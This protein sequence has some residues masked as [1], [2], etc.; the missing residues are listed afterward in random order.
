MAE[1]PK[2]FNDI[3]AFKAWEFDLAL[4]YLRTRRKDGGIAVI[5]IISFLGIALAVT[6]LIA[7]M[8]IM[9]GFQTE[10]MSRLLAFNGHA[11]VYGPPLNALATRDQMLKSIRSLPGI[12][13]ASPYVE[14]P[15]LSQGETTQ[16]VPAF[17]RGVAPATLKANDLIRKSIDPKALDSFGQGAFG[18]EEILIGEGLAQSLS[19]MPGDGL[20]LITLGGSSAFGTLPKRKTYIVGGLFKSG[21][22]ELDASF[23]YMPLDQAALFFGREGDWD[24]VEIKVADP[25]HIE[26]YEAALKVAAGEGAL[27]QSWKVRNTALWSALKFE[28]AA[29]R[30]IL[31]FVVMIA[32]L[33]II[34]GVVMLVKNKTR[35]IAILRTLGAARSS[36]MRI[37]F[38]SG[39]MIGVAGTFVGLCLG[40]LFVVFIRPIQDALEFIFN[41]KLFDPKIYYLSHVPAQLQLGEVLTI[42]IGSLLMACLFTL[43]PARWAARLEPVEALRYE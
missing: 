40:V 7:V 12:I 39:A 16:I 15:A 31:F 8:S 9:N 41:A 2:G 4:R 11:Y 34:S 38:L 1:N 13:E 6:A 32:A 23:I 35:D 19:V 10:L 25:Y 43:F 24:V 22:S 5:A 30:F 36:I 21:V 29:M 27:L 33:N 18:G 14:S 17:V 20:T 42:V 28:R 3:F 26:T 37:F